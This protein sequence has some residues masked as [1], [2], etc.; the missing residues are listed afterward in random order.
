[1]CGKDSIFTLLLTAVF[2]IFLVLANDL[3]LTK[4]LTFLEFW[5]E[6]HKIGRKYFMESYGKWIFKIYMLA[7]LA[8]ILCLLLSC[9]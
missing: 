4:V 7:E 1:M 6:E 8:Y 5:E 9:G 2:L 3:Q